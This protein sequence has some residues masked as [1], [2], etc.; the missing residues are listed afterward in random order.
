MLS[1][2]VIIS[3]FCILSFESILFEQ[4]I[5]K[6]KKKRS[7]SIAKWRNKGKGECTVIRIVT[8]SAPD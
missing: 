6:S 2:V 1:W 5:M 3:L 8:V 7:R 4:L